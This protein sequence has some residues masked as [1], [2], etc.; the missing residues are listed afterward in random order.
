MEPWGKAKR[1]LM[2]WRGMHFEQLQIQL[3]LSHFILKNHLSHAINSND[4]YNIIQSL[5]FNKGSGL[6]GISCKL[7]EEA[8]PVTTPSWIFNINL[9]TRSCI[10]PDDWKI[11][12]ITALFKECSKLS[13]IIGHFRVP[14]TLTFKMRLGAKPFLWKWV[15]FAWEWKMISISKAEHLPSF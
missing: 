11:A 3:S 13:K 6:Y 2:Q 12:K 15:L 5:N 1:Q 7:L 10:F 8:A 14:K 4:M 9:A